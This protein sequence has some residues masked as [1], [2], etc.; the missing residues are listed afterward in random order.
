MC[1]YIVLMS[2]DKQFITQNAFIYAGEK[3]HLKAQFAEKDKYVFKILIVIK[4]RDTVVYSVEY[5]CSYT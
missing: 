3:I 5:R 4:E 1:F 2:K